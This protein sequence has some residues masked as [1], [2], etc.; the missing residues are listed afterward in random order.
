MRH[1]QIGVHTRVFVPESWTVFTLRGFVFER[2]Y[3]RFVCVGKSE[4]SK[5]LAMKTEAKGGNLAESLAL[6][7]GACTHST[8]VTR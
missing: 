4:S 7:S 2:Q 3:G 6:T 8:E 1:H 5:D